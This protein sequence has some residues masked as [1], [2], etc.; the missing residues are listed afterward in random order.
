MQM[1][2]TYND[3]NYREPNIGKAVLII[4]ALLTIVFSYSLTSCNPYKKLP[5]R[6]PLSVKDT[7]NLINRFKATIPPTPPKYVQGKTITKVVTKADSNAVKKLQ[8]KVDSLLDE[9]QVS[10]DLLKS[11]PNLDSLRSAIKAAVLADCKPKTKTIYN[12]TVDTFF[13]ADPSCQGDKKLLEILNGSLDKQNKLQAEKITQ[14]EKER[15]SLRALA[16]LFV[17]ELL[18]KWWFWIILVLF[19]AY[20]TR[21]LWLPVTNPLYALKKP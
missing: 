4:M 18:S 7:T 8:T 3:L 1:K 17:L 5:N 9:L 6:P 10:G 19:L 15:N 20:I 2:T 21:K 11:L 14:Y 12:N 13:Q 16:K